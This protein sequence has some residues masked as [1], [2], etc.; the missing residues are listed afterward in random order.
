[1]A[2]A[3]VAT[4]VIVVAGRKPSSM[5][6]R[7]IEAR[8]IRPAVAAEAFP[9]DPG[10]IKPPASTAAIGPVAM[11][12]AERHRRRASSIATRGT[13]RNTAGQTA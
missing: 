10:Q 1:M 7:Q 5:T 2:I 11:M 6:G 8:E 9:N 13:T 3:I 12:A 4:A